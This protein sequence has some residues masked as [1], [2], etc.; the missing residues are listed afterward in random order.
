[1][2]GKSFNWKFD[3]EQPDTSY[4]LAIFLIS[5]GGAINESS[6]ICTLQRD[7]QREESITAQITLSKNIA[8]RTISIL[9]K[10]TPMRHAAQLP[11]TGPASQM[12][13][14]SQLGLLML[15]SF[16]NLTASA[17]QVRFSVL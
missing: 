7:N 10:Y 13:H 14:D 2:V 17:G 6:R 15:S 8:K 5:S 9:S 12:I 11:T 4:K 16:I 3:F 1:M